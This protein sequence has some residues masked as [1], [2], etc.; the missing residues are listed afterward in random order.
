MNEKIGFLRGRSDFDDVL[1]DRIAAAAA[2]AVDM[3]R[4]Q[5]MLECVWTL[6]F[7]GTASIVVLQSNDG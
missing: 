3:A 6:D 4:W 5:S 1:E 7:L 2:V